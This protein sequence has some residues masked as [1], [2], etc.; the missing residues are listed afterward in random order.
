MVTKRSDEFT[1]SG[2]EDLSKWTDMMT[3][4]VY[5]DVV[6]GDGLALLA[7]K[8]LENYKSHGGIVLKTDSVPRTV[9]KPAE[10]LIAVILGQPTV[11]EVVQARF[12]LIDRKGV[13]FIH[14]HRVY[15]SS[16]GPEMSDWLK[17]NG[18]SMEEELMKWESVSPAFIDLLKD[19]DGQAR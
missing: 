11:I 14:S 6:D 12:K 19:K 10:H 13:A 7:N 4:N 16:V 1:P 17:K 3:I 9:E 2:Q 18:P 5:E 15:G 8:V